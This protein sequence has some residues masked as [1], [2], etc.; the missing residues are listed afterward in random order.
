MGQLSLKLLQNLCDVILAGYA[1]A[2][3]VIKPALESLATSRIDA[4]VLLRFLEHFCPYISLAYTLAIY[5]DQEAPERHGQRLGTL[6]V[7]LRKLLI[8]IPT[9][10]C[11]YIELLR[12][13]AVQFIISKRR[14]YAPSDICKIDQMM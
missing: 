3:S 4:A 14:N 13:M 5:D 9:C 1:H 2:R 12:L 7:A 11:S 10:F 8:Q 6:D